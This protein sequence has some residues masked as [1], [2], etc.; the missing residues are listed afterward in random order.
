M[1]RTQGKIIFPTK[2]MLSC[3]QGDNLAAKR[4]P[5][6]GINSG[7]KAPQNRFLTAVAKPAA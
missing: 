5:F 1:P 2:F 7:Q 4:G 6:S 3:L